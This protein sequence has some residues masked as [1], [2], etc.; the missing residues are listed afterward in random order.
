MNKNSLSELEVTMRNT[1]DSLSEL[2][3]FS[4]QEQDF[5]GLEILSI[6][7]PTLQNSPPPSQ[8]NP[9]NT[10]GYTPEH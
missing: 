4:M 10:S 2:A 9:A 1:M 8:E 3:A 5:P 6:E 7:P